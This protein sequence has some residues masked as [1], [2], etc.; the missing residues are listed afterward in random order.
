VPHNAICAT[1]QVA[2]DEDNNSVDQWKQVL[3]Y[4][5]VTCFPMLFLV[6]GGKLVGLKCVLR[7]DEEIFFIT[8]VTISIFLSC[9]WFQPTAGVVDLWCTT[10]TS[11]TASVKGLVFA[12][13]LFWIATTE[14]KSCSK[15][16][17]ELFLTEVIFT[18]FCCFFFNSVPPPAA[19]LSA[20]GMRNMD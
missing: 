18:G 19:M 8:I 12:V 10:S 17:Q 16:E 6:S 7:V 3:D 4:G 9:L 20:V 14:Y 1:I 15:T 11:R 13:S 5:L 2:I